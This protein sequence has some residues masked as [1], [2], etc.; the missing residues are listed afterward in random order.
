[1]KSWPPGTSDGAVDEGGFAQ[2]IV[3]ARDDGAVD[4]GADYSKADGQSH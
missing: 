4:K 2:L 3:A 1:M